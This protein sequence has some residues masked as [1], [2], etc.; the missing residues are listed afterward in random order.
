MKITVEILE[1]HGTPA[2]TTAP[3]SYRK[4]MEKSL[5]ELAQEHGPLAAIVERKIGRTPYHFAVFQGD[6]SLANAEAV[7]AEKPKPSKSKAK[8][9]AEPDKEAA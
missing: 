3:D 9:K 8:A 4:Q 5:N 6:E 1:Q 7:E 2:F